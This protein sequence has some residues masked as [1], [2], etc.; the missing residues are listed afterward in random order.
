[1]PDGDWPTSDRVNSCK[2]SQM[3]GCL[4]RGKHPTLAWRG[5]KQTLFLFV[6]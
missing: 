2:V 6:Y 1:M 3:V 5:R 4:P